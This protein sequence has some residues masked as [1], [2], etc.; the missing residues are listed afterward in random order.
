MVKILYGAPVKEEIKKELVERIKRLK[1]KLFLA[2]V[3]VGDR[4]DSNVYVKNKQKFGEE[5]GAGVSINKFAENI[6]EE[7]LIG[8]IENLNK[9]EKING[10][11]VQLPL[12][13]GLDSEKI[14]N[15]IAKEKDADGL[16]SPPAPL[17]EA[18]EGRKKKTTP[19]TARA[20]LALL[21]FYQIPM[22]GKN[23]AVIGRSKLAGAPI[24]EVLKSRGANV[25]VCNKSTPNTAQICRE[26]DILISAAGQAGLVTKDFVK[27]G[28]VVVD[29]GI[30]QS[31]K[32]A[33][34]DGSQKTKL[35]GDVAFNEVE[36]IVFA[37]TPVPGGVGPLTVACLFQNLIDLCE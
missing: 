14:L 7:E 27:T 9:D 20:V 24:A 35:V 18:G 10:I 34:L 3:Q 33:F 26:A 32:E 6:S 25:T 22:A 31:C 36:P 19:A 17:L 13:V 23:V 29:V 4:A 5:I 30:N 21:D 11:I 1:T 12:S 15:N 8:E 16:T 28:Q 37:I 2:I